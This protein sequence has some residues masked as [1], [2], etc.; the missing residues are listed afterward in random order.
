MTQETVITKNTK[1]IEIRNLCK[2]FHSDRGSSIPALQDI[3]LTVNSGE[4][5]TVLGAT[6]CG[7][8]TLLNLIGLLDNPGFN[9]FF[10]KLQ[11]HTP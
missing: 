1:A 10:H 8:T 7:K 11:V 5:V 9:E 2:V 4:F 3:N 6:G